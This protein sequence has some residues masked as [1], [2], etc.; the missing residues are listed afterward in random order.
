MSEMEDFKRPSHND[1]KTA[2]ELKEARFNGI[3]NNSVSKDIECWIE[4]EVVFYSSELARSI[5]PMDFEQKYAKHFGFHFA[6]FKE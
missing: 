1:F 2:S 6:E 3:R 5:N 4:G